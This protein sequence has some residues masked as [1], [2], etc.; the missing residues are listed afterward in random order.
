MFGL[1]PIV[2]SS[3]ISILAVNLHSGYPEHAANIPFLPDFNVRGLEHSGH[4]SSKTCPASNIFI[5]PSGVLKKFLIF[6]HSGYSGHAITSPKRVF[7]NTS[8]A[9]HFSHFIP[10]P[11]N[12]LSSTSSISPF[13]FLLKLEVNLHSGYAEQ[14]RNAP[15][16]PIF[17][18][19]SLV[20][21]GHF[22][23][24]SKLA[25][26]LPVE[27]AFNSLSKFL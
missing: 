18:T 24:V 16:L 25:D 9:P 4:F 3:F 21:I 2:P 17:I 6:L 27:A 7:L 15:F 5:L 1:I 13:S 10:V 22:L 26:I 8:S 19:S 12:C 23:L 11:S 14:A 20:H